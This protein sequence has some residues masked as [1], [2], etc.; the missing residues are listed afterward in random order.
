VELRGPSFKTSTTTIYVTTCALEGLDCKVVR[1]RGAID[2]VGTKVAQ[3]P[4][5]SLPSYRVFYKELKEGACKI[6]DGNII[7]LM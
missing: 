1:R 6:V 2:G 5:G 3:G 7:L 4:D